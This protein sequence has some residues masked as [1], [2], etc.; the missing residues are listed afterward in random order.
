MLYS[1]AVKKPVPEDSFDEFPRNATRYNTRE[2][3]FA[4]LREIHLGQNATP[5]PPQQPF[6][7]VMADFEFNFPIATS[8]PIASPIKKTE[9]KV[10][11]KTI[12]L[13]AKRRRISRRQ[14]DL[15]RIEKEEERIR[16]EKKRLTEEEEK[17]AEEKRRIAGEMKPLP[18]NLEK[19]VK[20]KKTLKKQLTKKIA[21]EKVLKELE[22]TTET[23]QKVKEV[24]E[25]GKNNSLD[26]EKQKKPKKK[27]RRRTLKKMKEIEQNKKENS[28]EGEK[29]KN[30]VE[31]EIEQ[32]KKE[33]SLM[34]DEEKDDEKEMEEKK[35]DEQMEELDGTAP[36]NKLKKRKILDGDN[37]IVKKQRTEQWESNPV[38]C[39]AL[40]TSIY[41]I[42]APNCNGNLFKTAVSV[43]MTISGSQTQ[44]GEFQ[45]AICGTCFDDMKNKKRLETKE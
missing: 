16:E 41:P 40:R 20:K 39:A 18:L 29:K 10:S 5:P 2:E 32:N 25:T 26:G 7:Q 42:R 9:N 1:D 28:L 45:E 15:Q 6:D 33:N 31:T 44:N 14:E 12:M 11:Q 13:K 34:L 21:P 22:K 8:T 17:L 24:K 23:L 27:I 35:N 19:S 4:A 38:S 3:L 43:Q 37:V 36:F 30:P